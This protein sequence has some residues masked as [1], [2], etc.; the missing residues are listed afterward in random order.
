MQSTSTACPKLLLKQHT[1]KGLI[2]AQYINEAE[3]LAVTRSLA[4][5]EEDIPLGGKPQV[6]R[7]LGGGVNITDPDHALLM[8][9]TPIPPT[10][11]IIHAHANKQ[12]QPSAS[13]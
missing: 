3:A 6:L 2:H 4:I 7:L 8:H 10:P 12:F 5:L 9:G 1:T 11:E 13:P